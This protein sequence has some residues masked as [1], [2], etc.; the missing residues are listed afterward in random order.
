VGLLGSRRE[1]RAAADERARERA[2]LLRLL[3]DEGLLAPDAP[4]PDEAALRALVHAFLRRTPS[5][6]VGIALDDLIGETEP[7]N[8]PGV[9][10]DRFASWTRRN[11]RALETLADDPAVR[12]A[13][14]V[15]RV[16]VPAA[17][18]DG[19]AAHG[20]PR[21]RGRASGRGR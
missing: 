12:R 2:L 7:V 21:S 13:L 8:L 1:A 18:D 14:G 4:P 3:E 19:A 15:E 6:L 10:S 20:A 11:T 16:W 17:G 5:W 9:G